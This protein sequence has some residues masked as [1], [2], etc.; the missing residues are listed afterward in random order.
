MNNDT[1]NIAERPSEHAASV[2]ETEAVLL[3]LWKKILWIPD[4]GLHDQFIDLGGH[5]LSATRCI[6][7]IRLLFKVDVPIEAF[8]VEPADV[9]TI[10]AL[11]D[12]ARNGAARNDARTAAS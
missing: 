2:T 12:A 11:I 10:A 9:A 6:N 3:N 8:F 5:S 1:P 7:K 4:I